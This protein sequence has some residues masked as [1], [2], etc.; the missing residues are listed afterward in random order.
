MITSGGLATEL[1]ESDIFV[2]VLDI[3]I[4]NKQPWN[5]GAHVPLFRTEYAQVF[6]RQGGTSLCS[7]LR[8]RER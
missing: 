1:Y 7:G 4:Y 8:S 5:M 2:C 3:Q 6:T